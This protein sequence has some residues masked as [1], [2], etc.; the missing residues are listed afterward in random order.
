MQWRRI[1]LQMILVLTTAIMYVADPWF[2]L[3]VYTFGSYFW[4]IL[5]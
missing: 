4:F 5:A 3:L 2:I 1:N